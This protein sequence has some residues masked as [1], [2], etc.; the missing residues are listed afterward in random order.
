MFRLGEGMAGS[1]KQTIGEKL[2]SPGGNQFNLAK[3]YKDLC[4]DERRITAEGI[5]LPLLQ[6]YQHERALCEEKA[7]NLLLEAMEEFIRIK[8]AK[9][10]YVASHATKDNY[11]GDCLPTV[12]DAENRTKDVCNALRQVVEN[13][14]DRY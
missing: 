9:R 1:S 14:K 3:E 8:E 7:E 13:S 12:K 5:P 11:W 4:D 10:A 6:A 2:R